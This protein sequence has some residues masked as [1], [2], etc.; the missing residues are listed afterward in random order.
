MELKGFFRAQFRSAVNHCRS[1][2]AGTG[3][4]WLRA[5]QSTEK[6]HACLPASAQLTYSPSSVTQD[7]SPENSAAAVG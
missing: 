5:V 7:P 2:K 6:M 4:S 3:C 1:V